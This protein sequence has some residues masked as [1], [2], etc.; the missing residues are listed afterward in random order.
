MFQGDLF[1]YSGGEDIELCVINY[2][3]CKIATRT[4]SLRVD[5]SQNDQY[6]TFGGKST[7]L[8]VKP[9]NNIL[10]PSRFLENKRQEYYPIYNY[11]ISKGFITSY[12]R[13]N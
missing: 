2:L 8:E 12:N 4:F 6:R 11:Y 5:S 9:Y 3:T 10:Y 1:T 7:K 13:T